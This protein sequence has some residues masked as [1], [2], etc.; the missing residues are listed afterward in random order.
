MFFFSISKHEFSVTQYSK[1]FQKMMICFAFETNNVTWINCN[2]FWI[3]S[4]HALGIIFLHRFLAAIS[5]VGESPHFEKG[6]V[7]TYAALFFSLLSI[8]IGQ[9]HKNKSSALLYCFRC[10]HLWPNSWIVLNSYLA[11]KY[12]YIL[13]IY[14]W[15]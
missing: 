11:Q 14:Y 8:Y 7:F 9:K 12:F 4:K 15:Q 6:P 3:L 10:L 5:K 13:Q 2:F 1:K